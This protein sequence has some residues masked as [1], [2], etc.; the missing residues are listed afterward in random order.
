MRAYIV[1]V[2]VQGDTF[3]THTIATFD[4][5]QRFLKALLD[6]GLTSKKSEV[7]ITTDDVDE[8]EINTALDVEYTIDANY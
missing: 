7:R 4:L 6:T 2:H 3:N 1:K 8:V 5:L